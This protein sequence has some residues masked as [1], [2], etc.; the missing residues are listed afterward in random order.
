MSE[1]KQ[2]WKLRIRAPRP[3]F[4]VISANCLVEMDQA[5][6]FSDSYML[7]LLNQE[8]TKNLGLGLTLAS[9]VCPDAAS[10]LYRHC[11]LS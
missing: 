3:K 4:G 1:T 6:Y 7:H 11:R 9:R 10:Q 5:K 8:G 2:H